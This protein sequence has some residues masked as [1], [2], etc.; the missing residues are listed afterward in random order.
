MVVI[1]DYN[2]WHSQCFKQLPFLHSHQFI[3]GME[4][5]LLGVEAMNRHSNQ[6]LNLMNFICNKGIFNSCL[7]FHVQ[8][9]E[10]NFYLLP[11]VHICMFLLYELLILGVFPSKSL[12]HV[13]QVSLEGSPPP[14][15][16][17]RRHL[18]LRHKFTL[19]FINVLQQEKKLCP[20]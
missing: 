1:E 8:V 13:I 3:H 11:L 2:H 9:H 15:Q 14:G 12:T 5:P 6:S 16:F 18:T 4:S 10:P 17:N 20:H 19:N 7:I